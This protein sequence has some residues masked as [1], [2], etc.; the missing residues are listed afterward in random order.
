MP[1]EADMDCPVCRARQQRQPTCRRCDAD[2]SL[3]VK[4]L[5][6]LDTARQRHREACQSGDRQLRDATQRYLN[7]LGPGER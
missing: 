5:R 7:W 3:Y 2:L 6:S 1:D 4:A